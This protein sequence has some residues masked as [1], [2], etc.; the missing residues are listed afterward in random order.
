MR[1]ITRKIETRSDDFLKITFV[2][3]F[4]Q[5]K[6]FIVSF[7]LNIEIEVKNGKRTDNNTMKKSKTAKTFY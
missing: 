5:F 3:T 6:G 2:N 7:S 1:R 4:F